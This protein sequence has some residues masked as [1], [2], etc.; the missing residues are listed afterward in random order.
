MKF[1]NTLEFNS[2]SEWKDEYINY[3]KLKGRIYE[4]EREVYTMRNSKRRWEGDD[5]EQQQQQQQPLILF[6][7]Q[8]QQQQQQLLEDEFFLL[9][10][11]E[12][13]RINKF[14]V[15][16]KQEISH[17]LQ[18]IKLLK[19]E[20]EIITFHQRKKWRDELLQLFLEL[21]AL[22]DYV[23]LNYTGFS[24]ITKK[25]D[26][27]LNC[28]RKQVFLE[29][30][31]HNKSEF[32]KDF[33][34]SSE[35]NE[36]IEECVLLYSQISEITTEEAYD[37]LR[38][39]LREFVVW[40]RSSVW[41]DMI[42]KERKHT[43]IGV[44][45][46]G[47]DV[48]R[49]SVVLKYLK[50]WLFLFAFLILLLITLLWKPFDD[51]GKDSCLGLFVFV[52]M[53]WGME[54]FPLFVTAMLIP[55]M[56]VSIGILKS[57][58]GKEYLSGPM[59]A[60]DVVMHMFSPVILLL[61]GGFTIAAALTKYQIAKYM[62][63]QILSRVSSRSE[64]VLL[65]IM[66][67]ATFASMWLSNVA[68]PVLCYSVVDPILRVLDHESRLSKA[69]IIGIALA[70]NVGGIMTPISSPQN[71]IGLGY[72]LDP[73]PSWLEWLAVSVPVAVFSNL[74]IWLLLLVI[75]KP[76][77][78]TKRIQ[79][80]WR[81]S[82]ASG[83]FKW[84]PV[85]LYVVAVSLL[86]IV[87]WCFSFKLEQW[88]GHAGIIGLVP[89]VAF[90][91]VKGVLGKDEFNNFLWT[92]VFLAMG[93]SALGYAVQNS[94]LLESV[95]NGISTVLQGQSVYVLTVSF[96]LLVLVAATCISHTVSAII[97]LPVVQQVGLQMCG[98]ECSNVMVFSCIF[99]CS[100]AMGLPISGFPN[101][102]AVSL[103]DATGRPYVKTIDFLKVG[104][105]AS[106]VGYLIVI[107]LG[108]GLMLGVGI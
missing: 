92:V 22:K 58:D 57:N 88:F 50:V 19:E 40:E 55:F 60:K 51:Y 104:L 21:C 80:P 101:I 78:E 6:E 33:F 52:S 107:S 11:K 26:K 29:E 38:H 34:S 8:Q 98:Q 30:C 44:L 105:L 100:L 96:S 17:K 82:P 23:V 47:V 95:A 65:T 102:T 74:L 81:V 43:T 42:D 59:A 86:T 53:L 20:Q 14:Y 32:Y 9:L 69:L 61:L 108:Y 37:E 13:D 1:S 7:E 24:K 93:G 46:S 28:N 91:G 106:V 64:I 72:M 70:S 66:F 77:R 12:V 18:T 79:Q 75:Y 25:F 5:E 48:G 94:G 89:I 45:S 87:L 35:L 2:L 31:I 99:M 49:V 39:F 97:I 10:K 16:K 41:K 103:E 56:V 83:E 84:T 15:K 36:K 63:L 62:A 76:H 90:F 27:V 73:A 4:I 68:A 54:V 85:Q 67:V 71:A 3:E